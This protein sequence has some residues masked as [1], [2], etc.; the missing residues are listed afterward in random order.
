MFED[1]LYGG[2]YVRGYFVPGPSCCGSIICC[3]VIETGTGPRTPPLATNESRG[4]LWHIKITPKS[5]FLTLDLYT[6]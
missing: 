4:L 6:N 5:I 2:Y 3:D 1:T